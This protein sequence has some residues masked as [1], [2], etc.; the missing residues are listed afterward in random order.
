[1]SSDREILQDALHALELW[2]RINAKDLVITQKIRAR[3]AEKEEEP[4]KAGSYE[5]GKQAERERIKGII[6]Y[7][8]GDLVSDLSEVMEMIDE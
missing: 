8:F 6:T 5:K 4:L 2:S 3:L 7:Q 1:M